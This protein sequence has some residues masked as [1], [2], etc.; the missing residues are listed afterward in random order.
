MTNDGLRHLLED[1]NAAGRGV[2]RTREERTGTRCWT[3]ASIP[4]AR[5]RRQPAGIKPGRPAADFGAKS[6]VLDMTSEPNRFVAAS[7]LSLAAKG[8]RVDDIPETATHGKCEVCGAD[9]FWSQ[10]GEAARVAL[11]ALHGP[12][13]IVCTQCHL[14]DE[15]AGFD[16]IFVGHAPEE[17]EA[18]LRNIARRIA[19]NN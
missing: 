7:I 16:A 2:E 14:A 18:I 12:T 19:A 3:A 13:Q 15:Q 17:P 1:E 9:I 8:G 6:G 11:V 5:G 4:A 10:A